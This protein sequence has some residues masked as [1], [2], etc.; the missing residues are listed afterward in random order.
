MRRKLMII[1]IKMKRDKIEA[2]H[3]PC[4]RIYMDGAINKT[5][6]DKILKQI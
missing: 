6:L 1:Q 3:F 4:V 5:F 2:S